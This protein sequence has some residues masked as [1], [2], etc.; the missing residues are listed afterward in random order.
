MTTPVAA[1]YP[2]ANYGPGGSD[3][4]N[5]ISSVGSAI[6]YESVLVVPRPVSSA[7]ASSVTVVP[8]PASTSTKPS[9]AVQYGNS[10]VAN[11]PAAMLFAV[12]LAL[13]ALI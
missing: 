7:L 10:A 8:R 5:T 3:N 13:V 2:P 11:K 6:R 4:K 9:V 1:T 12:A